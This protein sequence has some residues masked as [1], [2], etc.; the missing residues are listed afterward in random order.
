[1]HTTLSAI[2]DRHRRQ[3]L[4]EPAG[5]RAGSGWYTRFMNRGYL[6]YVNFIHKYFSLI[7]R[8]I[9]TR[10]ADVVAVLSDDITVFSAP[11]KYLV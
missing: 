11:F 4:Q 3:R 7:Q 9:V 8:N 6:H 2:A 10:H 1:M 5:E